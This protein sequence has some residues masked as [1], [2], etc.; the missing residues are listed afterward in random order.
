MEL[1]DFLVWLASGGGG[2]IAASWL[3]ERWA[4]FQAKTAEIKELILWGSSAVLAVASYALV[5]YLPETALAV[6]APYFYIVSGI[7]VT[8]VIGKLFHKVDK[9]E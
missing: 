6:I 8:V 4:W 1:K 3:L 5:N 7:F 9:T 2:I